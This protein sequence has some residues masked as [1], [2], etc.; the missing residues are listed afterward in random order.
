MGRVLYAGPR[1]AEHIREVTGRVGFLQ[2]AHE[3]VEYGSA[4]CRREAWEADSG[5]GAQRVHRIYVCYYSESELIY[6]E[7]RT[8]VMGKGRLYGFKEGS[9]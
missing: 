9:P 2:A 5:G 1:V 4:F 3:S 6:A 8:L 7:R